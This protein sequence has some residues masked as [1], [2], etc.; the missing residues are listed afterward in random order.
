[1][2][3]ARRPVVGGLPAGGGLIVPGSEVTV[4]GVLLNAAHGLFETLREMGA[5]LVISNVRDEGGE[6]WA[7]SPPAI[8][9]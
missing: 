1:M 2:C 8:R 5:D 6:R 3:G 9:R 7:T 4:E